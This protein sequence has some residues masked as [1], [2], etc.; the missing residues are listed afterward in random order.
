MTASA[1]SRAEPGGRTEGPAAAPYPAD[2]RS[3]EEIVRRSGSDRPVRRIVRRDAI[4]PEPPPA[5]TSRPGLGPRFLSWWEADPWGRGVLA[6]VVGVVA[7]LPLRAGVGAVRDR[8]IPFMPDLMEALVV[9]MGA[10]HLDQRVG[11]LSDRL[12]LYHPGPAWFYWA[13]PFAALGRDHPSDLML[14]SLAL[15]AV[16]GVGICLGVAR[17]EG[18]VAGA[19][20]GV[21]LLAAYHQLSL[22]GLAFPWIPTLVI[23]PVGAGLVCAAISLARGSL[24]SAAAGGLL[25]ALVAQTYMGAI[26]LGGAIIAA[27]LVGAVVTRRREGRATSLRAWVMLA[28]VLVVPWVPMVA[29]QVAGHGNV[30]VIA[31]YLATGEVADPL[32][33]PF[34]PNP[35]SERGALSSLGTLA[36]LTTMAERDTAA[37]AGA[38]L[39]A[40]SAQ[41]AAPLSVV[42]ALG[43]T[44]L[45]LVGAGLRHGWPTGPGALRP[46]LL[47]VALVAGA[48]QVVATLRIAGE[49][50][51][52]SIAGAAGVGLALW[53]GV[54][55]LVLD[56]VR[57]WAPD[58]GAG[59]RRT[60]AQ[61]LGV[62]A[63]VA[64]AAVSTDVGPGVS[65]IDHDAP[66]VVAV[67]RATDGPVVVVLEE[68]GDLP[69]GLR[70]V[71]SLEH[72]GRTVAVRGAQDAHVSDRQRRAPAEGTR[73][74]FS[75]EPLPLTCVDVGE[76]RGVH[77]CLD[78]PG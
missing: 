26:P 14:A 20:S 11:Q 3:A 55:L 31:R 76:H 65:G 22:H 43:L 4:A 13:A 52:Y 9:T 46:W 63:L 29:D 66:E 7:W 68:D 1:G 57:R 2:G 35:P 78:G 45:A 34:D 38:D 56:G 64:L 42:L 51:P 53:I 32:F 30:G 50:R 18:A 77:A 16:C 40:G 41:R 73:I 23:L 60:G 47:R 74:W 39:P 28:L 8:T 36:S 33:P 10:A 75:R 21:V 71:A 54:A 44:A 72:R 17:T 24:W 12:G 25:G 48:L 49:L 67:A 19:V 69:Y 59:W 6:L 61:G 58:G 37:W 70:V 27:S 5:P 15:V 62:A